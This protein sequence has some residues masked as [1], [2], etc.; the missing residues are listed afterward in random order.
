MARNWT[1]EARA[2]Q[3]ELIRTWKPWKRSTGARTPQ[4][5]AISAQN[6]VKSLAAAKQRIEDARKALR[7]AEAE[8]TRLTGR[9]TV[10]PFAQLATE[11]NRLAKIRR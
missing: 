5:K 3:S 2:K 10:S 8:H 6:R 11:M 1:P 7:E 4:G 9:D